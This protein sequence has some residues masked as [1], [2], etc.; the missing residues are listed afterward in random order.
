MRISEYGACL[1]H[2]KNLGFC[3]AVGFCGWIYLFKSEKPLCCPS[4]GEGLHQVGFIP[5]KLVAVI[6]GTLLDPS[7]YACFCGALGQ[8]IVFPPAHKFSLPRTVLLAQPHSINEEKCQLPYSPG[9][10]F[11]GRM[12]YESYFVRP[13]LG[14]Y[15]CSEFC[16]SLCAQALAAPHLA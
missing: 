7:R 13:E 15:C 6:G 4:P 9:S 2:T 8:K 16:R 5:S 12:G 11:S 3:T 1:S 14:S 10:S